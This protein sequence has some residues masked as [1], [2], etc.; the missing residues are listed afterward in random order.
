VRSA[1]VRSTA[2]PRLCREPFAGSATN[3][4]CRKASRPRKFSSHS[5][6]GSRRKRAACSRL[7][8]TALW[9]RAERLGGRALEECARLG[10]DRT[11]EKIPRRCVADV[12]ANSGH[13]TG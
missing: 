13:G 8:S 7:F 4:A 11:P 3:G 5:R 1:R 9:T 6:A 2:H 10:I 12:E